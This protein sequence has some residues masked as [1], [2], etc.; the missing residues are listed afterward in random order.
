[1]KIYFSSL[2]AEILPQSSQVTDLGPAKSL[3]H[4]KLFEKNAAMAK[5]FT[6]WVDDNYNKVLFISPIFE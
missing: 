6:N 5:G 2:A 3:L 4:E 1:M